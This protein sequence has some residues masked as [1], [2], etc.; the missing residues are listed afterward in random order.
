MVLPSLISYASKAENTC[1]YLKKNAN[2]WLSIRHKEIEFR[3]DHGNVKFAQTRFESAR[4]KP[5]PTR[6]QPKEMRAKQSSL[7]A[8][9]LT[10]P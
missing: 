8:W 3:A 10:R 9:K 5:R 7:L 4:S 2:A 1:S 6:R